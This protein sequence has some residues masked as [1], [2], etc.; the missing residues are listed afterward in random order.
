MMLNM[1]TLGILMRMLNKN[2]AGYWVI[3]LISSA[4]DE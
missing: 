4:G 3:S 2:T 1:A